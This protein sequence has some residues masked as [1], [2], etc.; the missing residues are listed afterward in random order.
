MKKLNNQRAQLRA[1]KSQTTKACFKLSVLA[2]ATTLAAQTLAQ[3]VEEIQITGSRIQ[4]AGME[5]PTPVTDLGLEELGNID[6]GQ[7]GESLSK[8]PQFFNN[9]RPSQV[10]WNS[11]GANLNLRGAGSQRSLVLLDG[12]RVPAGNRWGI[13]NVSALPEAAIRSVQAVTGGASA[14]Y[15]TDAVAGVINFIL[16]TDYNGTKLKAQAGTSSRADGDNH[17]LGLTHGRDVG[18]NGHLLF[19]IDSF[20]QQAIRSQQALEDR[21][22]YKQRARITNP[23]PNGPTLITRDYVVSTAVSTGGVINAPNSALHRWA[24]SRDDGNVVAGPQSFSGVGSFQGGCNCQALTAATQDWQNDA[25]NQISARNDRDNVFVYYD[26]DVS[27]NLNVYFQG[28]YGFTEV[29]SPWFSTPFLQG[30]WTVN[31][32]SGNPFLPAN[33]QQIMDD[34]GLASFNMALI[35]DNQ[36]DNPLGQYTIT[37]NDRS[38]AG[39]VGFNLRLDDAGFFT[40][41]NIKG[42]AQYGRVDQRQQFRNGPDL[43]Y[44]FPAMD[45]VIG[46]DGQPACYAALANPTDFGDCRP[47]NLLGGVQSAASTPD[48]IDYVMDDEKFI[49]SLYEQSFAEIT[50]DGQLHEGWGA[51]PILAFFGASHRKDEVLQQ[52]K[53]LEDEFVFLGGQNTGFRGLV[54]E[55]QPGGMAGIRAGSVPPGFQGA[56]NL[57]RILFT[58][59]IQTPTTVLDG[60]FTVDEVFGEVN[61]PLIADAPLIQQLDASLAY[62]YADYS[63]SGG[64][65]SWKMGL[66]WQLNDDLRLRA[67]SSRD[68]RAATLRERFDETAGG[69]AVVDPFLGN[70]FIFTASRNSGNPNVDPEEADTL[71]FGAVYQPSWL[72][73]F[74][75]SGDWY[76]IKIDGAMAQ[77]PFQDIVDNCFAG[78]QELCDLIERSPETGQITRIT[79]IYFNLDELRLKGF[80]LE[81]RYTTDVSFFGGDESLSWRLLGN[82]IDERSQLVPGAPRDFLNRSDPTNRFLTNLTYRR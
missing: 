10:G 80:D 60:S 29:E 53:E 82:N 14:A 19:S 41:W 81:M 15:G 1:S 66:S 69:A 17:E 78:A 26:H 40:D 46:P 44:L 13:P 55:G 71:T 18:D 11:A 76:D 25:D 62:R 38:R 79:T 61:V 75:I 35:G 30:P 23:D 36:A 70:S 56:G 22:W 39:T 6:P 24:F 42:Y 5:S 72:P 58:G 67:T 27:D 43:A 64:I 74:S 50:I 31:I 28:M 45:A 32:F 4:R 73:G 7:L 9:Q 2:L 49:A 8:L 54:P 51:G 34:E 52:V 3:E 16:D 12:R 20:R 65:E 59:S 57:S 47:I 48:G 77:P 63:G 37:Q 21:S 68:V 33:V